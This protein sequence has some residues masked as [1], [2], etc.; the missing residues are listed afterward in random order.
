MN[1]SAKPLKNH[2]CNFEAN[3]C[4]DFWRQ[5]INDNLDWT[6]GTRENTND[7]VI[8]DHTTGLPEGCYNKIYL[9][10]SAW[11]LEHL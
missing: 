4:P 10:L 7:D 5:E 9:S 3:T 11:N 2:R 6:L 1:L 8:G